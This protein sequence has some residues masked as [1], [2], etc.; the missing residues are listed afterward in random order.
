MNNPISPFKL[1]RFFARHEFTAKRLLCTSDCESISVGELL[2]ME[3]GAGE[4]LSAFRLGY[5]ETRGA[6]A[7]REAIASLHA[8]EGSGGPGPG[9]IF[10]H[11]GAAEGVLNLLA[12][13]LGSKDHVIV[14]EPAY[15]SL[16]ELPRWLGAAVSPW[17]IRNDG[18]RW[19][20]DPDDLHRLL[21]TRT[22]L[23]LLNVPHNPTG[24]LPTHE[25]Y[26][27]IISLCRNHGAILLVDE[28]YRLLERNPER[29]LAPVCEAYE[30]GVSLNVLSKS[31]GLAGLRIG[32]L[33]TRRR[34]LL[35]AV[36]DFKDYNS[37]CSSGPSEF[38]AGIAI[39]NL[40]RIVGRNRRLCA[41]NF[42]ALEAFLH[43]HPDFATL[44]PPE[45][46]SVCFP[47]LSGKAEAAFGGDAEAMTLD[48]LGSSGVLLLP[49]SVYGWEPAHFRVGFGR[50]DFREG[51]A[52]LET[53]ALAQGY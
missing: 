35:D 37:I 25:E 41:E 11:A 50:A 3:P 15:Q 40:E 19:R 30:K 28:V 5:T 53:W 17:R 38:L 31:A 8:P 14:G 42:R 4:R 12:S 18:K 16:A 27:A 29:R 39:R 21:A 1:E 33:A 2:A 49:G 47:R 32:W 23:V 34:D 20:F 22:K 43:D 6:P 10:V 46:S 44:V 45:G 9:G 36:A 24:A 26:E 51:L 13:I 52:E 48:L 7:L